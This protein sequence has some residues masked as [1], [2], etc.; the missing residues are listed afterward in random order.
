MKVSPKEY[1]VVETKGREDLDDVEKIKRLA[2]WCVDVNAN[3][4]NVVYKMLYIKQESWEAQQQK[5]AIFKK[6]FGLGLKIITIMII[7]AL[8]PAPIEQVMV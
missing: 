5:L 1:Y 4:K 7:W 2:Q 6:S 3:Q 8:T